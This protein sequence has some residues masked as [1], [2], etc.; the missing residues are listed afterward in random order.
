MYNLTDDEYLRLK[1]E[2][3]DFSPADALHLRAVELWCYYYATCE[4]F[5]QVVCRGRNERGV[6][7]PVGGQEGS[8]INKHAL[9]MNKHIST[10]AAAQ[11]IPVDVWRHA[12]K[13]ASN[14]SYA[15]HHE[16]AC[17]VSAYTA[18]NY[19]GEK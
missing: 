16:F 12:K 14:M 5:D 4:N 10:L 7:M 13:T 18:S 11:N 9:T 6:A 19:Q 8:E 15:E 3:S 17:N 2:I 1:K